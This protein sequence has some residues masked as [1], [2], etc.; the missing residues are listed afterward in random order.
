MAAAHVIYVIFC[1]D[2]SSVASIREG[3]E[4]VLKDF[5]KARQICTCTSDFM[6]GSLSLWMEV[7]GPPKACFE[8][9]Y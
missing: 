6:D 2:Q 4:G 5:Q 8:V 9:V 3:K 7:V 1:A